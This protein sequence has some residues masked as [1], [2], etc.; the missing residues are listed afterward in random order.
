MGVPFFRKFS[1]IVYY[2]WRGEGGYILTNGFDTPDEGIAGQ[3]S[4]ALANGTVIYYSAL[5]I[6]SAFAC[7]RI[8]ALLIDASSVGG[9]LCAQGAL[10]LAVG[11]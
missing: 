6:D 7:T 1:S 3:S 8:N 2:Y 11:W 4:I 5:C 10:W 9:T